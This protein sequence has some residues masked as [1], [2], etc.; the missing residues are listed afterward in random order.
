MTAKKALVLSSNYRGTRPC[1]S[2]VTHVCSWSHIWPS[3]FTT[4]RAPLPSSDATVVGVCIA[5]RAADQTE[6]GCDGCGAVLH[7]SCYAK[8]GGTCVCPSP[9]NRSMHRLRADDIFGYTFSTSSDGTRQP[10]L[11]STFSSPGG[12]FLS[13]LTADVPEP[14]ATGALQVV[15]LRVAAFSLFGRERPR[16]WQLVI[17][18][19]RQM[20]ADVRRPI[21]FIDPNTPS[22][23]S[24][25]YRYF[26]RTSW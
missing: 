6:V 12:T 14:L 20:R 22:I 4:T 7:L 1:P 11:L 2:Q 21:S 17:S 24:H 16:I 18:D 13:L 8:A 25:M 23:V 10:L 9:T 3:L 5:C 26:C 19:G 15:N